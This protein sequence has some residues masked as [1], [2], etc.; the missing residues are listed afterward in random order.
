MAD[1]VRVIDTDPKLLSESAAA[2]TH[3]ADQ[4]WIHLHGE[5]KAADGDLEAL[6][7][8]LRAEE[9]YGYTFQPEF[10]PDGSLRM[11]IVSTRA[12]VHEAYKRIRGATDLL[13][14]EPLIEIRGLWY[15]F[16][17]TFAVGRNKETGIVSSGHRVLGLFP[18]GADDGIVGELVWPR[19]PDMLAIG[20]GEAPPGAPTDPTEVRRA[21]L[22]LHDRFLHA[23]RAADVDALVSTMS[24]DVQGGARDYLNDT[25]APIELCDHSGVREHYTALFEKF[26]ILSVQLLDRLTQDWYVFAEFRVHARRRSD[27]ADVAFNLAEFY[28]PGRDGRI[29]VRI[30]YGSDI[31][32]EV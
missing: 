27:G 17:E 20:S 1:T 21:L 16:N 26:Q 29:L 32:L 10:Q 13:T 18:V 24:P 2:A 3:A 30:G 28:V 5:I 31:A 7:G 12:E 23:W 19:L 6:L 4:A 15:V 25:G 22:K 9:P 8:T 11:P 14:V